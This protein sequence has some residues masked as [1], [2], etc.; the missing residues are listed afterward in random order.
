MR[1]Y[2]LPWTFVWVVTV[3]DAAFAWV[4]RRTFEHWEMN[5]IAV[6]LSQWG[7]MPCVVGFRLLTVACC[8]VAVTLAS[9]QFRDTATGVVTLVHLGLVGVYVVGYLR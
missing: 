1:D 8:C 7:G 2:F 4:N 6:A 9:K 3:F 5:P